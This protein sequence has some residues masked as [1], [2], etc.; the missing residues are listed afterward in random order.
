MR[1]C[2]CILLGEKEVENQDC[3]VR[4]LTVIILRR[5]NMYPT[6]NRAI[7]LIK[8]KKPFVDWAKYVNT[9]NILS[10]KEVEKVF[11]EHN[12]YLITETDDDDEFERAIKREAGNIFENELL[13]WSQD[14]SEWPTKRSYKVFREWFEIIS[15]VMVF[16]TDISLLEREDD[17]EEDEDED[18]GF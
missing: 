2:R 16:D 14:E 12:A 17:Y 8:A 10:D 3:R 7:I 15:T 18:D 6:V 9:D 4:N 11:S 5:G 1:K 13:S